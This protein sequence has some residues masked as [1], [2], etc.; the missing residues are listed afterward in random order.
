MFN[1]MVLLT[2]TGI[3]WALIGVVYSGVVSKKINILNLS[4]LY[5]PILIFVNF[6]FFADL[7]KIFSAGFT[8]PALD[9]FGLIVVGGAINIVGMLLMQFGM[10]YGNNGFVFAIGQSALVLPFVIIL[11]MYRETPDIAKVI[12]TVCVLIGVALIGFQSGSEQKSDLKEGGNTPQN[13]KNYLWLVF[14]LLAFFTIGISQAM[15]SSTGYIEDA[16]SL[17]PAFLALGAFLG[18][19][20]CKAYF[21]DEKFSVTKPM[22][23]FSFFLILVGMASAK[24][25]FAAIDAMGELKLAS[26]TYPI[27]TGICIVTFALYSI[28]VLKEKTHRMGLAGLAA[29]VLGVLLFCCPGRKG[30]E[31]EESAIATE[32]EQVLNSST[33]DTGILP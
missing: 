31:P 13:K 4:L 15:F 18:S 11:A 33:E 16:Y 9:F 27:A 3:V 20:L 2:V 22:L 24:L 12:G 1:A 8:P 26:M 17:R 21:P 10:K 25:S 23:L 14:A 32:S 30:A 7:D 28:F 29:I 6:F 5:T 19:V